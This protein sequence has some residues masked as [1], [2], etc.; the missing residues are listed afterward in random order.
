MPPELRARLSIRTKEGLILYKAGLNNNSGGE[1]YSQNFSRDVLEAGMMAGDTRMIRD[2]LIYGNLHQAKRP[3]PQKGAERFKYHHQLPG[4]RLKTGLSTE[5]NASDVNALYLIG[6]AYYQR[7]TGDA[8]LTE[9]FRDNLRGAV[10]VYIF[11]H[12]N[13]TTNQ[14]EENPKFCDAEDF[15]LDRTD[16]KDSMTPGRDDGKV[17]Y[18]V[19][20]PN[21]Q[22][23]YMRAL[24]EA[25]L[26]LGSR[27]FTSEAVK[28]R[29]GLQ[30]LYD[31]KLG[32]FYIAVDRLSFIQGISSDGLNMFAYLDLEDLAPGQWEAI[33]K[34]SRVLETVAGYQNIDP[35]IAR[36][37]SDDYHA[38]VWP[39][40]N[41]NIHKGARRLQQRAKEE[42]LHFLVDAFGHVMEVSS[43]TYAFLDTYPE[44]LKVKGDNVV[45]VGCDPQLWTVTAKQYYRSLY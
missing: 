6:H 38:R 36:T 4:V 43:R 7:I 40:E 41:A 8:S 11:S 29:R 27:E 32:T 23:I 12:L 2:Q 39:K 13:P 3:D 21:L 16:W 22:A 24:R 28:M 10:E 30:A 19:V 5:Y 37:M 35:V 45:K 42:G 44:T 1:D 25:D 9:R 31:K 14:F 20:L 33:I 34:T 18:P 26:I 15:A 17:I